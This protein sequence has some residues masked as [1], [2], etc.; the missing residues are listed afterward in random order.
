MSE[1]EQS[2]S[3][4]PAPRLY[5][6]FM[7]GFHPTQSP[8]ARDPM[9]HS[10]SLVATHPMVP[11]L[12]T[13]RRELHKGRQRKETNIQRA[14][15]QIGSSLFEWPED[16]LGQQTVEVDIPG[17][18]GDLDVEDGVSRPRYQGEAPNDYQHS[19]LLT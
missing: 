1:R 10:R 5:G 19:G 14:F 8:V 11:A 12:T 4:S 3:L 9:N 18:L 6:D 2:S 13:R 16:L 7:N 17:S 15:V